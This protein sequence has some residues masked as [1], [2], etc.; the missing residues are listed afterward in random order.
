MA[1][2][3]YLGPHPEPSVT[4]PQAPAGRLS[5]WPFRNS[6]GR[7][8]VWAFPQG[9][10]RPIPPLVALWLCAVRRHEGPWFEVRFS[11]G[12]WAP[13]AEQL[14]ASGWG[15]LRPG[16]HGLRKGARARRREWR[17][18]RR[19]G[20][21]VKAKAAL[22]WGSPGKAADFLRGYR[23]RYTVGNEA[24]REVLRYDGMTGATVRRV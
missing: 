22:K 18:Y 16:P 11:P 13:F 19:I 23:G 20:T 17:R 5:A 1:R 21:P 8:E 10:W 2:A 3:R 12:E 9:L 24:A 7:N 4:L 15:E 6:G 14:L